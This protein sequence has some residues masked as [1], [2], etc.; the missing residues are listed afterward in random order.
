[1]FAT[2]AC[3]P[4]GGYARTGGVLPRL[5]PR[6]RTLRRAPR[7]DCRR[8]CADQRSGRRDSRRGDERVA[9]GA[10][11]RRMRGVDSRARLR[12][13]CVVLRRGGREARARRT[14]QGPRFSVRRHVE[15]DRSTDGRR[16][17]DQSQQS[18]GHGGGSGAD[19]SGHRT[20]TTRPRPPR[21]GVRRLRAHHLHR[22]WCSHGF[23]KRHHRTNICQGVRPGRPSRRRAHR[24]AVHARAYPATVAALLRQCLRR[25]GGGGGIQGRRLLQLV[26]RTS[27]R[28]ES[29][30][31]QRT[32]E[33]GH[34]VWPSAANFVLAYFGDRTPAVV[35]GLA[36][37]GIT[38]RDR[39]HDP[40]CVGC[41]RITAGV[42]PHTHACI[43]ALEEVLCDAR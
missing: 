22:R 36:E 28:I 2:R 29:T 23:S 27:R 6:H 18:H 25:R 17:P 11:P 1:M 40:G 13:V 37:R 42:V 10:R 35:A 41:V 30:A 20:G 32:G 7:R 16:L 19:P 15:R 4:A 14:Q 5:R 34:K 9:G 8:N 12:H 21:R 31:Q 26:S 24:R 38:V 3:R 39:S 43:A 33:A